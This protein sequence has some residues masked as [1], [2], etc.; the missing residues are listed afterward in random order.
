M[1]VRALDAN[2]DMQFGL[3]QSN[4]LINSPEAV[5]QC[6]N[7]RL[8]LIKGEWFL[9]SSEGTDWAGKI[10]GRH[11]KASYDGE[12]RRVIAGTQ[13]V[14]QITAYASNLTDRKL[15]ISASVL[16]L[17][18]IE[19]LTLSAVFGHGPL[20]QPSTTGFPAGASPSLA[21][22]DF[23]FVLDVSSLG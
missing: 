4:F 8:G 22:L 23:T 16:T 18:S 20:A 19:L 6:I 13:G 3:S 11:G 21:L 15:T 2:G 9:D 14:A 17:Y 10:L 1:R 7:T 5:A 12:I